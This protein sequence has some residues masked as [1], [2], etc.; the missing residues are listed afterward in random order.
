M[1]QIRIPSSK[2]PSHLDIQYDINLLSSGLLPLSVT[3]AIARHLHIFA[4]LLLYKCIEL[5][6][7]FINYYRPPI[8]NNLLARVKV[9]VIC[10]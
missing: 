7:Q 4:N 1:L 5:P 9:N 2:N 6:I 8:L 10:Y 3:E